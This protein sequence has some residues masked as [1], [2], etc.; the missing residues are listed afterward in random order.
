[1]GCKVSTVDG[2]TSTA[3]KSMLKKHITR[4]SLTMLF[5]FS[6]LLSVMSLPTSGT[7]GAASKKTNITYW[8]LGEGDIPGI[9]KWMQERISTYEKAH[10]NIT[11]TLVSQSPTTVVTSFQLAAQ[12]KSGPDV[13]TQWATL[14]TLQPA[15]GGA[16]TPISNFLPKSDTSHWLNTSENT[17]KGKI[18][19]MPLY[20][21]G[22]P[23]VWNKK[24]FKQAGLNPNVAPTTWA[25]F[26]ADCKAL[27]AHGITPIEMG[28]QEGYWGGWLFSML[29]KQQLNSIS[30]LT[31]AIAN[32]GNA[33]AKLFSSL[34]KFYTM[35]Q[36]LI[37]DG[38]IN[39]NVESVTL[40]E[41]MKA[42]GNGKAGMTFATDG[43]VLSWEKTIGGSNIGVGRPPL[44]GHGA[45]SSTYD[46]SQSTDEFITS[47]S[48][49]KQADA[50]FLE[51][52]HQPVNMIALNKETGGFPADNQF[53]AKDITDPL[54]KAL[55]K[56]DTSGPSIWLENYNPVSIDADADFAAS[57]LITSGSGT[58]AQAVA[59]WNQQLQLWRTQQPTQFAQFKIWAKAS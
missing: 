47:W 58:P 16:V 24:L 41:G 29:E 7:A 31:Q 46:V 15:L 37:K 34:T 48:K 21:I 53:P 39:S 1:M 40:D 11:V 35:L 30:Q 25:E 20:L 57:Q 33:Q 50:N 45:L 14:P 3:W 54:A 12:S 4:N 19:A 28:N 27:K 2:S 36:G 8:F 13:D 59:L 22:I 17:Y 32:N 43:T 9:T 44:W 26:L 5:V 52:L 56:L 51:W 10:P 42:F 55:Y 38:Y 23:L 18:Y 49:N 6:M